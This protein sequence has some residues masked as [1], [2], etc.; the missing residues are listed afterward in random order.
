MYTP[1]LLA[2]SA[3]SFLLI[4]S[5]CSKEADSQKLVASAK[6]AQDKG[7]LKAAV[8]ELKNALQ[9]NPENGEARALL[10]KLYI[11]QAEP[12][13]AEKELRKA[14]QLAKDKNELL[15][16]LGQAMLQQGQFQKVI[17]EVQAPA[18]AAPQLRA[19]I[20]ALRGNAYASLKQ[21]D[22]A[23]AS[24]E[25]ARTLAPELADAYAG[26]AALA[27]VEQKDSEAATQ[28]DNAIAKDPKRA[29]TWLLKGYW[30]Q[31]KDKLEEAIGA[32]QEAI[33]A[34]PRSIQAHSSLANIYLRQG[35]LDAARSEVAAIKKI[36]PR[37][38]EG[39]YLTALIE[40][41]QKNFTAARDILQEVLKFAPNHAPS[42]LLFSAT[43]LALGS[44]GQA[45]QQLKPLLQRYPNHAYA[46][47]LLATAQAKLGQV[48]KALETLKP[49]L[50]DNQADRQA[51]ALAGELH[52][53]LKQYARA[54]EYYERAAKI[55]PQSAKVRTGLAMS[56][57]ATGDVEQGQS[58]LAAASGMETDKGL[59]DIL[60]VMT[61]TNKKEWDQALV[62][63]DSLEKKQPNTPLP[64][65]MRGTVYFNKG[66]AP[67][68]RQSF[69]KAL[70]IDPAF[71]PAAM[72][73]AQIDMRDKKPDAARKRFESVLA[74]DKNNLPTMLALAAMEA[75]DKHEKEM[76]E[77]LNKAAT[78]HPAAIAPRALLAQYYVQ[79]KDPQHALT[80]AREA[81]NA[82]PDQPEALDLLG[83]T[84]M[85][86]GEKDNALATFTKWAS[87][88]P[89]NP[90]AQMRLGAAQAALKNPSA[91]RAAYQRAIEIKPDFIGAQVELAQVELQLGR[92]VEAQNI[93]Q[94]IQKQY[95][96]LAQGYVL[97][98][99]ILLQ[100]NQAAQ[101]AKR[102]GAALELEKNS[103]LVIR[104]HGALARAGEIKQADDE[105]RQWLVKQ[106]ADLGVRTYFAD[107]LMQNA[108]Y[109][110]AIEQ[111]EI[112]LKAN[113]QSVVALNN[114]AWLYQQRKDP[115]AKEYGE[116][117]L[118]ANPDNP[119]V[120]DTLGWIMVEQNNLPRGLELLQKAL[121]KA[122]DMPEVRYHLA[123]ALARSGDKAGAKS[124]LERVLKSGIKFSGEKEAR[125]LLEQ[126]KAAR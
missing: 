91:A 4:V 59:A 42:V 108:Q 16:E 23:R 80:I 61:H 3:V 64:H 15:P 104:R 126:L 85:V 94:K 2:V 50:T 55:S 117:A 69:E 99:D 81:A 90:L 74:K 97:E 11:K 40:F 82:N 52:M 24:L 53:Q 86:A 60:R 21:H 67:R 41:Q 78:A 36:D 20:L 34:D 98:G 76:L 54:T 110:P 66:D 28:I 106:P 102:Y 65:N 51:L 31:T 121:A 87:L 124:E 49:L 18:G 10:G 12:A 5:G 43:A 35:K 113:A 92:K 125:A 58:D 14:M 46:R 71:F 19:R 48:E 111:Y 56:R 115:R 9:K 25:E 17:D 57:Y 6:Q 96:K 79:K 68:A 62:A 7:D 100:D 75:N 47:K 22:Q 112:L 119:S 109:A 39:K 103:G 114:L 120:M 83:M 13:S 44:Y 101:A 93:A 72:N 33:K 26:L 107:V 73:L 88:A 77:W 63:I 105:V 95:P 38:L 122:P 8:I 89:N 118:K 70:S 116:R 37:H 32:Y 45:E 30:L 1:R 27:M 29:A 123:V 84:Q